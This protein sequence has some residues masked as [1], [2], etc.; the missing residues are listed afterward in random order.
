MPRV[1]P[2]ITP[3][4]LATVGPGSSPGP[5]GRP[6]P[7]TGGFDY[8]VDI[9]TGS[10]GNPGTYSQPWK[11][12]GYVLSQ[13]GLLSGKKIG[14]MRGGYGDLT[15]SVN[16]GRTGYVTLAAVPGEIPQLDYIN[17]DYGTLTDCY[18]QI[19]GFNIYSQKNGLVIIRY[20]KECRIVGCEIHCPKSQKGPWYCDQPDDPVNPCPDGQCCGGTRYDGVHQKKHKKLLEEG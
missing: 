16:P 10:D 14:F 6:T 9:N 3:T 2:T 19:E 17:I 1:L 8:Y 13:G 5:F 20:A 7:P 18:L 12:L 15:E 4:S 11:T